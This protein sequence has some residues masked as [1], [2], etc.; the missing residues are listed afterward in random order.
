MIANKSIT[1][2]CCLALSLIALAGCAS[3]EHAGT[4]GS[5]QVAG[6]PNSIICKQDKDTGSRLSK[7]ICKT[8]AEWER[9]RLENQE[10]MRNAIRSPADPGSA[11]SIGN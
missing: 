9:E 3:S 2:A 10:A 6:D 8:A 7:R 5:E 4:D 1:G 11:P